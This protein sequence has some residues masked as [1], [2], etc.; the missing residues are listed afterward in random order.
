MK[1]CIRC[2]ETKPIDAFHKHKEMKDGHLNKCSVCVK[3]DVDKW[4]SKNP[5]CRKKE[6]ER[7]REKLGFMKREDWLK[8]R[9]D[10]AI[11][12]KASSLKY[13]HKRRLAQSMYEMSEF[14]EFVLEEAALLCKE[15]ELMTGFKWHVDHIVPVFHKEACGL[16]S[17]SNIQVVP[18]SWNVRKSNTNMDVFSY[19][20]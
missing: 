17:A 8:Q 16:N 7:K 4:R 5:D 14:D 15:R 19:S 12:R 20:T 10:N 6:H 3:E 9:A 1:K 13:A 11:G 2:C 18:A